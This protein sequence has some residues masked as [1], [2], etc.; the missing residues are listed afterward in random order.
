MLTRRQMLLGMLLLGLA[1]RRAEGA[2]V[3]WVADYQVKVRLL[4]VIP[5]GMT[6]VLEEE[7]DHAAGTYR[8]RLTGEGAGVRN[9]FESTGV[10]Q[11]RRFSPRTTFVSYSLRGRE[12]YSRIGYDYDRRIVDYEH[13]SET[14]WLGNVRSGRNTLA[15]PDGMIL[16]DFASVVL[17]HG[18]GLYETPGK[19]YRVHIVRRV[20]RPGEGVDEVNPDGARGEITDLDVGFVPNPDGP[21]T[22]SRIDISRLSSWTKADSPAR[23]TFAADGKIA[24]TEG[25]FILGTS[26][27]VTFQPRG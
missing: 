23:F 9:R 22:I 20:Q 6:G 4:Y 18:A 19:P 25:R 13:R 16:D 5:L 15:I 21:G 8:V 11:G 24:R 3:A 10:V 27:D 2:P 26:V 1:P 7:T 14:F 12:H 17:N